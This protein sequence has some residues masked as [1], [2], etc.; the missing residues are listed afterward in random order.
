MPWTTLFL[1]GMA[2]VSWHIARTHPDDVCRFLG[3]QSALI[4][5]L[6]GVVKAPLFLQVTGLVVLLVYPTCTSRSERLMTR[7]C[8]RWCIRRSQ[9]QPSD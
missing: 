5:L 1:F 2:S 4:C 6:A 7:N 9:C 8:P 3:H